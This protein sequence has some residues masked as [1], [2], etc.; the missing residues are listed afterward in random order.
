VL[1]EDVQAILP[2]VVGHR[3]HGNAEAVKGGFDPAKELISSVP[4]PDAGD[5]ALFLLIATCGSRYPTGSSARRSGSAA[6]TLIQRRIFIL[7]SSQGYLFAFVLLLLLLRSINYTSR[8]ATC[9]T[10]ADEHGGVAMLHTWR[11]LAHLR[12]RP[13][14]CEPSSAGDIAHFVSASRRRRRRVRDRHP[15]RG[16]GARLRR[17]RSRRDERHRHTRGQPVVEVSCARRRSSV[18]TRY[19]WA[20]STPGRTS[21]SASPSSSTQARPVR[22]L[23]APQ[24]ARSHSREGIPVPARRN[25]T[26]CAPTRR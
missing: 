1:P 4:I 3:L 16:E 26:C 17:R 6:V 15:R 2:A 21:T 10:S 23:A 19:P 8:S 11:N 24:S 12:L 9:I 7:P 20:S 13:G 18:F 5:P 22:A 25:S 14:R